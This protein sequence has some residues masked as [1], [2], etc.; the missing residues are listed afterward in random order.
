MNHLTI[1]RD[2]ATDPTT[3]A[4][5]APEAL[6]ALVTSRLCHDLVSPLGAIGNGLELLQM[7]GEFA[8]ITKSPEMALILDSV[9]AARARL[10]WF[11][12]AFGH[13]AHDQ[14]LSLGELSALLADVEKGGRLKIRLEAEG[15]L[16]RTEA[17]LI[18]LALMCLETALPWGGDILICRGATGWRLVAQSTRVKKDASLWASLDRPQVASTPEPIPSEVHFAL[19]AAFSGQEQRALTW[20]MDET[21]GEIAF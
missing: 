11:R 2:A 9:D 1:T 10:R 16:P 21:G 20:E 4:V 5:L 13:A 17:R 6:A 19:L 14:R 7:S 8:G 3:G 12:V 15:D 18:L